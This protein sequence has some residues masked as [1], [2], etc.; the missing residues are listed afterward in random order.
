MADKKVNHSNTV[1]SFGIHPEICPV[2]HI[3]KGKEEK[4]GAGRRKLI[5]T[6]VLCGKN[7]GE[8]LRTGFK[9]NTD[10]QFKKYCTTH[11]YIYYDI[12]V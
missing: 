10:G 9:K 1:Y 6:Q 8:S 4:D 11:G 5:G 2:I 7:L 12:A 3:V